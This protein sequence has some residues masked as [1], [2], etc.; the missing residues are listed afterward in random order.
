[1]GIEALDLLDADDALVLRLMGE[2]R[3]PGDI[4]DCINAGDI[5][6]AETVGHDDAF[7]TFTPNLRGRDFR[8]ADHTHR[9]DDAIDGYLFILPPC[10]MMAARLLVSFS[11]RHLGACFDLE[12]GFSSCL[13]A[14]SAISASSTGMI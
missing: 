11:R 13:R 2:H 14:S 10:S 12:P 1:M 4:A 9:R 7:S 5:G 8:V 3:R 6:A